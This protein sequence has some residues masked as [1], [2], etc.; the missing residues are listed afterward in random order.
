MFL[1][2]T[3]QRHNSGVDLPFLVKVSSSNM[4]SQNHPEVVVWVAVRVEEM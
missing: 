2:D 4:Y 3:G 1:L